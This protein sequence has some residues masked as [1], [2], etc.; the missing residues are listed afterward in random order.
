MSLNNIPA[1]ELG[2]GVLWVNQ[3][4]EM[5]T[6]H[7]HISPYIVRAPGGNILIEA[8]SLVHQNI[9]KDRINQ[10]VGDDSVS[11]AIVSHYDLP[12]AANVADFRNEWNFEL[13][14]SF[15]GTSASPESLG[16]GSSHRCTHDADKTILDRKFNFPWPPLV[17]AAHS[18]WVYDYKSKTLFAADMG[19][20]HAPENCD[21]SWQESNDSLDN[22][23]EYLQDALPFVK[24][25]DAKKMEDAFEE[26]LEQYDIEN[27][28]PVHGTPIMGHKN[29]LRYLDIYTE[30]IDAI[31]S[32]HGT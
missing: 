8:G 22:I 10:I 20:Y 27:I 9:L 26:L 5:D 3:C 29:V 7:H 11:A 21:K 1:V 18:M 31:A 16:M 6:K 17:D 23:Q 30:A 14:T 24:Y 2:D 19:H 13:Y 15:E 12:H 4:Y 28:A 25:L 32:E